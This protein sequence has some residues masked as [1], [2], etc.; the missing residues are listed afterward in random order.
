MALNDLN[1]L[2]N[3]ADGLM[4]DLNGA[5]ALIDGVLKTMPE[6]VVSKIPNAQ[7]DVIRIKNRMA[8]GDTSGLTELLKKNQELL[9]QHANNNNK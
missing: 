9:K 3:I 8:S 5:M 7:N 4:K 1:N 6:E 2:K